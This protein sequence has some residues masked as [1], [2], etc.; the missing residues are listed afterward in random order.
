MFILVNFFIFA[1]FYFH[2]IDSYSNFS[3]EE[4]SLQ[5]ESPVISHYAK[6]PSH[7]H[8]MNFL[9]S[10]LN[11]DTIFLRRIS[12]SSLSSLS[13]SS[14]NPY[15]RAEHHGKVTR[16]SWIKHDHDHEFDN[17]VKDNHHFNTLPSNF[18]I[19]VAQEVLFSEEGKYVPIDRDN[20]QIVR[21]YLKKNLYLSNCHNSIEKKPRILEIDLKKP[22]S[23][24]DS[25]LKWYI[26]AVRTDSNTRTTKIPSSVIQ[27]KF[28]EYASQHIISE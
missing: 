6:S 11:G 20:R 3:L 13:S 25:A 19:P 21:N 2:Q 18:F 15:E 8:S 26:R 27:A 14:F 10:N 22:F 1:I 12:S 23:Y 24:A 5:E 17:H 4:P 28:L 7:H 16:Y 9:M